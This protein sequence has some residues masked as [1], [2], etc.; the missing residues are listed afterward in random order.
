MP[1]EELF[2]L[3]RKN[4]LRKQLEPQ[5]KRMLRDARSAAL[6]D[7]FAGQWLQIRN[8]DVVS[9][10]KSIYPGADDALIKSM[11]RETELFVAHVIQE[12]RSVLELIDADYSFLNGPLAKLYG[13][14][15]VEGEKFQKVNFKDR[16]RGGLLGQASVLTITSNPTRTS[17]VKRG[18]WVLDNLLGAPPPPPPPNVPEL[19][20]QDGKTLTG[21]LRQRM[22]QHREKI[23]RAHV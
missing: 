4:E 21:T 23:G 7:N 19:K 20:A 5:V 14:D 18:K 15:G 3:A 22:E 1:D 17:P 11:R 8:L 12:D 16:R 13:I 2:E 9:P 6:V 10:D